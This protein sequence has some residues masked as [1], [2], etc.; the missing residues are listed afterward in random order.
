MARVD[1]LTD[2]TEARPGNYALYD[3]TQLCLGSCTLVDC[4]VTVLASVV[5]SRPDGERSVTDAGAL[6][7]SKDAGP[8]VP[9]HYGRLL[10][11]NAALAMH[12]RARV[13]TISQEHGILNEPLPVGTRVRILPNHACL[14]V[15]CFDAFYVVR[16]N[17][18]VDTWK[19][20]RQR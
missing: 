17:R 7:L 15:A 1:R 2:V 10:V 14:T 3:Y 13:L 19:I 9:V 20:W 12:P 5:S 18:L 8:D 6:A 4:A 11:D 16:G